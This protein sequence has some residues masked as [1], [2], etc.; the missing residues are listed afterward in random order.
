[1]GGDACYR[2]SSILGVFSLNRRRQE[3]VGAG[4]TLFSQLCETAQLFHLDLGCA[5]LF[6]D[7]A[8]PNLPHASE[9]LTEIHGHYPF[10]A[11]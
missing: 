1:M 3:R 2:T 8:T 7:A 10:E 5:A 6:G 4:R 9:I 11:N